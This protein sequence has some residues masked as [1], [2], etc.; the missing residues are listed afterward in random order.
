MCRDA[1]DRSM[2]ALG[3]LDEPTRRRLYLFVRAAGQP[4]TRDEC[5][6]HARISRKLAAFHLDRLVDAGLLVPG[7]PPRPHR[8]QRGRARKTYE[9]SGVALDVSFPPRHYDLAG[10]LL[11]TAIQSCGADERPADAALRIASERGRRLGTAARPTSATKRTLATRELAM[12]ADQ[13]YEPVRQGDRIVL[14]SCPFDAVARSA[15]EL[16]CGMNRALLDGA[17]RGIGDDGTEAVLEPVPG[18][19]CVELRAR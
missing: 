12:L 16:V 19:C 7:P 1:V 15:P 11:A 8:R 2:T 9:P 4:V 6:A 18:R 5:A 14:K 13:G 3:A 10:E 17:L